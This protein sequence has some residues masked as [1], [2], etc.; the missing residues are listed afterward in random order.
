MTKNNIFLSSLFEESVSFFG[1]KG[2]IPKILL[3]KSIGRLDVFS[4]KEM[5]IGEFSEVKTRQLNSLADIS[6]YGTSVCFLNGDSKRVLLAKYPNGANFVA[7]KVELSWDWLLVLVGIFRRLKRGSIKIYGVKRL[8]KNTSGSSTWLIIKNTT[9]QV[10][11]P[12]YLS[13]SEHVGIK[14]LI[15]YLN[16]NHVNYI[17]LIKFE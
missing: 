3:D 17:V 11:S 2:E 4:K 16:N 13:I 14:G 10:D 5:T 12:I 1:F 15:T 6:R 8:K 7:V 9:S